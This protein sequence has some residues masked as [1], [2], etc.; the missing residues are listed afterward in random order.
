V[1]RRKQ[2]FTE[3]GV[4]DTGRLRIDD[5]F[6]PV[7][8]DDKEVKLSPKEYL[9]L[10]LPASDPGRVFAGAQSV[11]RVRD[12][13]SQASSGVVKQYVHLLRKKPERHTVKGIAPRRISGFGYKLE[14]L[15]HDKSAACVPDSV[16][17]AISRT[18]LGHCQ[19][20]SPAASGFPAEGKVAVKTSHLTRTP[21]ERICNPGQCLQREHLAPLLVPTAIRQVII[22]PRS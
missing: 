6:K 17:P 22:W 12:V 1:L 18:P 8:I 2:G 16:T 5:R 21:I 13:N 19:G 15:Y 10:Q 11:S 3:E 7:S 14:I 9:M 4:L 20:K